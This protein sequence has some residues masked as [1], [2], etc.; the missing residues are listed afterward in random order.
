M[1]NNGNKFSLTWDTR[2]W[3]VSDKITSITF[4][5]N[6]WIFKEHC[7]PDWRPWCTRLYFSNTWLGVELSTLD[8]RI[9]KMVPAN[10]S[11]RPYISALSLYMLHALLPI[12]FVSLSLC[13]SLFVS[14]SDSLS[15]YVCLSF[16]VT[17]C[18]LKY[19]VCLCASLPLSPVF[20]V[21]LSLSLSVCLSLSL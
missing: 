13:L 7:G 11:I 21:F 4:S 3:C 14:L 2:N 17:I 8:K 20:S 19:S 5:S 10:L 1:Q 6:A 18:L 9:F 16:S 15:G 12:S